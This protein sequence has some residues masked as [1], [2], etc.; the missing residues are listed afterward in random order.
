MRDY[1]TNG[2]H[3]MIIAIVVFSFV[4]CGYKTAP[5]YTPKE[6]HHDKG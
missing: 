6:V 3:I 1:L 4:G 5:V 2:F